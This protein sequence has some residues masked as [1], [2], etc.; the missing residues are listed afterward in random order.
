MQF[1]IRTSPNSTS[2]K[3]FQNQKMVREKLFLTFTPN[4]GWHWLLSLTNK[5][6]L[7]YTG[8]CIDKATELMPWIIEEQLQGNGLVVSTP[9]GVAGSI[10]AFSTCLFH[11]LPSRVPGGAAEESKDRSCCTIWMNKT[12]VNCFHWECGHECNY[13]I[14]LTYYKNLI[15]F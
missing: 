8:M 11:V 12:G 9:Y 3:L 15:Y 2:Y 5:L 10:P 13:W 4:K 14:A 7:V 1:I 6:S